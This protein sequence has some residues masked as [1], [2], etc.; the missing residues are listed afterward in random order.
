[1]RDKMKELVRHFGEG[2]VVI[3]FDDKS[4]ENEADLIVAMDKIS[5]DKVEFLISEGRG[6]VCAAVGSQVA[7]G[8]GLMSMPQL[9]NDKH[10]TAFTI[11]VDSKKCTTGIS[12]AER[13]LTARELIR[14]GSTITD[15]ISPGH[16]FP[17]RAKKG[18][19][20]E[21]RGHTEAAVTLCRHAGLPEGALICEMT[22]SAGRMA[23]FEE[24]AEFAERNNI[25]FC[26][27]EEL[28]NYTKLVNSNVI[29]SA[30][31]RLTTKWGTFDIE[32]FKELYSDKEHV[33]LTM[34]DYR[35]G[36]VRIHSECMTGDVFHSLGCD[37]RMQL[38]DALSSIAAAGRGA[39]IYLRQEGRGIGLSA[40]INAYKLQ[41][42][43]GL[44][45]FEANVALGFQE[46]MRDYHQAAWIL[47]HKDF[48][49]VNLIS[50]NHE[51]IKCLKEHGLNVARS[52]RD[53]FYTEHNK[54]Y[55][56]TKKRASLSAL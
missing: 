55:I 41:Q 5:A 1:M 17:L 6:L 18:G 21:R 2:G 10:G 13:A 12:A 39:L 32:I 47:K 35:S 54:R 30:E 4:R 40:K 26:T 53:S 7:D 29:K 20:L 27:V 9:Y 46:D 49:D 19:I 15:F 36:E 23:T 33:L 31:S 8:L 24:T 16:L 22:G 34:G 14:P 44:D 28:V 45:T 50:S 52:Q 3:V 25:P 51:K 48:S 56:D 42:S 38:E 43:E 37:C 11:S